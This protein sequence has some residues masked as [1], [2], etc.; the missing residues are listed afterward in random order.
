[1]HSQGQLPIRTHE[2]DPQ[3]GRH[4]TRHYYMQ[5][6]R[7]SLPARVSKV[8]CG[9]FVTLLLITGII[10]FVLWLSLRPHRPRFY[11]GDFSI[12]GLA[13]PNGFA[14]AQVI[15]NVTDRNPNQH[16]GIYY[17]AMQ[18]TL[19]YQDQEIGGASLLFPFYQGSKNTTVLYGVLSGATLTVS[20]QRWMEFQN[21]L[22]Q[23]VVIFRLQLT[24]TIR[25]KVTTWDSKHHKMHANCD[26]GVGSDGS[27]LAIYRDKRC[28]TYFT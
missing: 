17:D 1:M 8:V 19:Y 15:F 23:G 10:V 27:I 6:V 24:S 22:S 9:T 25:F 28:P 5:R 11:V 16:I 4:H 13:Q 7:E 21:A 18:V 3:F 12:P 14:N 26:V 2:E 20:N